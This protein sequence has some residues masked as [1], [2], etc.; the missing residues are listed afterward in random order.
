MWVLMG[1]NRAGDQGTCPLLRSGES[2]DS[3]VHWLQALAFWFRGLAWGSGM[4]GSPLL[5]SMTPCSDVGVFLGGHMM[6]PL[7]LRACNQLGFWSSCALAGRSPPHHSLL[8]V[9]RWH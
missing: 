2:I 7:Q 5:A 3:M 4:G 1:G 9:K 8:P 6:Y